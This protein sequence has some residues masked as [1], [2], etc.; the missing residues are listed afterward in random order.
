MKEA[1]KLKQEQEALSEDAVELKAEGLNTA[2]TGGTSTYPDEILYEDQMVEIIKKHDGVFCP[3]IAHDEINKII[4]NPNGK[5][6]FFIMNLSNRNSPSGGTHWTGVWID[7]NDCCYFDSFGREPDAQTKREL[8]TLLGKNDLNTLRKFKYNT[9]D[10]QDINSSDC[11]YMCIKFIE[12][13]LHGKS[14]KEATNYT[15]ADVQKMVHE[16]KK[17]YL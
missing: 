17:E 14:F 16:Y 12:N 15:E 8:K 2:P 3:V 10:I 7:K 6:T 9:K 4:L 13:M 1:F 5:P 11:G